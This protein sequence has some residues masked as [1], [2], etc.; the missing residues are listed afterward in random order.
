MIIKPSLPQEM[1]IFFDTEN[2]PNDKVQMGVIVLQPGEKRPLEG[3][4]RH[5]QDEYSYVVSGQA[6]TILEDG[7]DLVGK[8]GDA[9]LIEAGEGHINYNDGDEAAVVVW[10]LVE[11]G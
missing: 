6:H 4:A 8:S 2:Q 5:D 9:Q 10:M 7:Q 1:T 3:F 11:R